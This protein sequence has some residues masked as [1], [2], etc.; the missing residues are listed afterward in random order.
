M[1]LQ[2][3]GANCIGLSVLGSRVVID[4]NLGSLGSKTVTKQGDIALFTSEHDKLSAEVKLIIDSPGEF[5]VGSISIYGIPVRTHMD[6]PDKKSGTMYKLV[7]GDISI[8]VTGHIFPDLTD[9][10][11]EDIGMVSVLIIPVGGNGFTLDPVG[12]LSI[13]KKIEPKIIIPTHYADAD[14]NFPVVQQTLDQA[15]VGLAMEPAEKT[16]K[17]KLKSTDLTEGTRLIVLE[18]A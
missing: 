2:F 15:L 18:R 3:F 9:Q 8:L 7:W 11:L 5:E 4:D 16:T 17:L 6:E 14:L 1:D 13:V 12:A 10:Q